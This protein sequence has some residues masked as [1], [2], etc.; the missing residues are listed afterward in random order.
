MPAHAAVLIV[1]L[2]QAPSPWSVSVSTEARVESL[3]YHF[4]NPSSFDTSEL[5][6][7]FFEQTYDTDHVWMIARIDHPLGRFRGS[8]DGGVTP[9]ATRR[10]DDFDTFF[11][12]D[13]NVIVYGTTGNASSQ[14]WRLSERIEMGRGRF[15]RYGLAYSYRRDR[16]RFHDG[17][18]ITTTTIP[19][20]TTHRLVTTRETTVSQLHVISWFGEMVRQVGAHD[21]IE[22]VVDAAPAALGRL[23]VDLPDKY[24]GQLL[25]FHAR[26][27]IVSGRATYRHAWDR[28]S[29]TAGAGATSTFSWS[30]D[31]RLDA[32]AL[33]A[34]VGVTRRIP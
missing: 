27:A 22:A 29:L 28:W 9:A 33:F 4:D 17:D 18:G 6:P 24:P 13:G 14:S 31:A 15:L 20:S 5:V 26:V 12:P 21:S 34:T 19:P 25:A 7:H 23:T 3:K 16:A 8:L 1:L 10:A 30:R 2:A 11:Q 32:R